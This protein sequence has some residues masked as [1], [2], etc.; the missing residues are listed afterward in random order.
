[1]KR[2][3]FLTIVLLLC[4]SCEK[5]QKTSIEQPTHSVLILKNFNPTNRVYFGKS[6]VV[7]PY[8]PISIINP[9][10]LNSQDITDFNNQ[11]DTIR[12]EHSS[13]FMLAGVNY[14][15]LISNTY[16]FRA[17]DTLVVDF[18]DLNNIKEYYLNKN[19]FFG[20]VPPIFKKDTLAYKSEFF[21]YDKESIKKRKEEDSLKQ[22]I[23][24]RN[25]ESLHKTKQIYEPFYKIRKQRFEYSRKANNFNANDITYLKK[26]TLIGLSE[27]QYFL[28]EFT[29]KKFDIKTIK[30]T[31]SVYLDYKTAFDSVYQS[32]IYGEKA[33]NYLLFHYL[34][35]MTQDFS[36]ND[37]KERFY[38]FKQS[39]KDTTLVSFLEDKYL[40]NFSDLKKETQEIY[41]INSQKQKQTLSQIL[42]YNRGKVIYVDF[43][44]S[45]CAPCRAL[46]PAS[47][48]LHTQYKDKD[49][50]FLYLS[51]DNDFTKWQKA[52]RDEGLSQNRFSLLAVNYPNADFY[53]ELNLRSIPRYLLYDKEGNLV[54]NNAPS[55]DSDI[56]RETLNQLLEK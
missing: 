46:M 44:A 2:F 29:K 52:N 3:L 54:H 25:L 35:Q 45:W 22:E 55:P 4:S 20:D 53:K 11:S 9:Y 27:Y 23:S 34:D 18:S 48:E 24:V 30:T 28:R 43:W 10:S 32:D 31:N 8:S 26:D 12:I 33:K 13:D 41:F 17:G 16:Y 7:I 49:V 47:K 50:V 36:Y 37:F 15:P 38:K 19:V 14:S 51:I 6:Y 21:D 5:E 42:E 40:L 56:L 1:M 39:T